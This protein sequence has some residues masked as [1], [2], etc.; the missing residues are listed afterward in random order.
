MS[1]IFFDTNLF[2]YLLE[3]FGARGKR[4][5]EMVERI[6][7]RRDQLLTS[8]MTLGEVLVKPLSV[9]DLAWADKYEQMLAT[10]GVFL[11]PFDKGAAR[12]Y[13]EIRQD[14][15]IRPPDAVQL[16]CAAQA[17]CDLFITNDGR[18]SKKIVPGIHFI[19]SLDR[20]FV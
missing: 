16:A 4:V 13:A 2:I 19:A 12:R 8:T 20:A 14:R 7:E 11:Q 1:R 15:S 10:P 5:G 18:L 3:D 9:H 17:G 6:A